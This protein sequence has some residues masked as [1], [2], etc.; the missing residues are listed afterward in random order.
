MVMLKILLGDFIYQIIKEDEAYSSGHTVGLLEAFDSGLIL[1][2][3][4]SV[5]MLSTISV[6]KG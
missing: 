1:L 2:L 6:G 3:L 5:I 4:D